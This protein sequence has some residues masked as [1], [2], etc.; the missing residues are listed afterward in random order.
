MVIRENVSGNH[1]Y[2]CKTD[3][4]PADVITKFKKVD[5]NSWL[6]GPEFLYDGGSDCEKLGDVDSALE[7]VEF[8]NELKIAKISMRVNHSEKKSI[9]NVIDNNRFND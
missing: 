9:G 4:N 6:R 8:K 7:S 3:V 5:I 1:W 2:H